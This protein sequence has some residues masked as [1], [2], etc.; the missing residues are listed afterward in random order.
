[1][2]KIVQDMCL[3]AW[4]QGLPLWCCWG[5]FS[6]SHTKDVLFLLSVFASV[7]SGTNTVKGDATEYQCVL[8]I[9]CLFFIT[10]IYR[11]C[12]VQRF[13]RS[14]NSFSCSVLKLSSH[15]LKSLTVHQA[16]WKL[17]LCLCYKFNMA[18]RPPVQ[19]Q[20]L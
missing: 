18:L 11:Y 14:I 20:I 15:G 10:N 7:F 13:V 5:M 6:F 16:V 12:R 19:P 3:L 17:V 4:K 8:Y 1:M 9:V 2:L